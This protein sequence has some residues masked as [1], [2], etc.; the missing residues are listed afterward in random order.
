M[1]YWENSN[2]SCFSMLSDGNLS[3]TIFDHFPQVDCHSGG[4]ILLDIAGEG[5]KDCVILFN[6][7]S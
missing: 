1:I 3:P 5:E 4:G 7:V 6:R 2:L